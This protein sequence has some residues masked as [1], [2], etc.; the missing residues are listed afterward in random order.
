MNIS[1]KELPEYEVAFIRRFGSYYEFQEHWGSLIDWAIKNKLYPP[2]QAF[3]GISLDNPNLVEGN[4]CRHDACVTIPED[5]D[6]EKHQEIQFKKLDGGRYA[7]YPFYDLPEKLNNA[8]QFMFKHWLPNSKYDVD[9]ERYNL[10]FNR[11]TPSEDPDGKCK[12]DLF[13]PIRSR[14]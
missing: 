14:A 12:V 13:I 1:V 5:F 8:Y 4:Y 7:L 10:E 3:I 11:N 9:Y 6:K 2:A